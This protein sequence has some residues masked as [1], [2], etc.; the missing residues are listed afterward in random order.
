MAK[1]IDLELTRAEVEV[2]ELE[3]RIRVVPMNDTQLSDALKI[4]LLAK[5]E[6]L[7]RLR[8]LHAASSRPKH[9]DELQASQ[10]PSAHAGRRAPLKRSVPQRS[11][12]KTGK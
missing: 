1:T 8:T 12:A 3:A 7:D 4:A 6:R 5:K 2:L 11:K 9:P 10:P